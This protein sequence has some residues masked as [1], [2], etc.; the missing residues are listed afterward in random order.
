MLF[1]RELV[2]TVIFKLRV[3]VYKYNFSYVYARRML[4]FIHNGNTHLSC[5]SFRGILYLLLRPFKS[6]VMPAQDTDTHL[7]QDVVSNYH[8]FFNSM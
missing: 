2:L 1:I 6:Q 3:V 7:V 5:I 8:A 4:L